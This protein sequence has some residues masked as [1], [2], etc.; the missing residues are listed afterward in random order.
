MGIKQWKEKVQSLKDDV[1]SLENQLELQEK[2]AA[3]AITQWEAR[4]STLEQN[5]VLDVIKQ[6]EER[7]QSLEGDV[8]LLED[9]LEMQEKEAAEAITQWEARCT[10]LEKSGEDVIK[11]WEE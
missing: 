7:V 8:A 1:S 10:T 6:W 11:Q 2:E 4:C 9:Q 3:E 5:G